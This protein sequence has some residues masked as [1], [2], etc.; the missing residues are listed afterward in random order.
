MHWIQH[1]GQE[2]PPQGAIKI[3]TGCLEGLTVD[4]LSWLDGSADVTHDTRRVNCPRCLTSP[5]YRVA[6]LQGEELARKLNPRL[7]PWCDRPIALEGHCCSPSITP[8]KA[9][10]P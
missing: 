6:H 8:T 7:C 1:V 5:H 10:S 9:I 3:V 4:V 2:A